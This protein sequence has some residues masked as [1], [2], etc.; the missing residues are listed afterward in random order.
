MTFQQLQHFMEVYKAGSFSKAARALFVTT[1]SLSV[2]IS[3]L[4]KELGSPLFLR[5]HKGLVLTFMGQKVLE[6]ATRICE[7]HR[8]LSKLNGDD[9]PVLRIA[10]VE[11]PPCA[12]AFTQLIEESGSPLDAKFSISATSDITFQQ[13]FLFELDIGIIGNYHARQLP[14]FKMLK[15]KGLQYSILKTVPVEIIIGP[16]HRLYHQETILPQDLADDILIDNILCSIS[17]SHYLKGILNISQE[18]IVAV[19]MNDVLYRML[20]E[21][22][23]YT[24]FLWPSPEVCETHKFRRVPLEDVYQDIIC[25]TNPTRPLNKWGHRF[26][27]LLNEEILKESSCQ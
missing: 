9:T 15:S 17:R 27:A 2:T 1:S 5:T 12:N 20:E 13:L 21:G 23:G 6:H 8:Q 16:K 10:A 18:N 3:N 26:L 25:V 11:Y 22:V 24:I 4:E 7:H 19:Q 14:L